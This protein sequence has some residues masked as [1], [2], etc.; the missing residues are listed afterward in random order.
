MSLFSKE[1]FDEMDQFLVD[2]VASIKK[3]CEPNVNPGEP[4]PQLR[5]LY[6]EP[7]SPREDEQGLSIREVSISYPHFTLKKTHLQVI[8]FFF[9]H[10]LLISTEFQALTSSLSA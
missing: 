9:W 5:S 2:K 6:G 3:S 4:Q 1:K 10:F 7:D 8:F